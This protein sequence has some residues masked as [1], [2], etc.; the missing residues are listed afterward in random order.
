MVIVY[1]D[2][3]ANYKRL[4]YPTSEALY[5]VKPTDIVRVEGDG[6]SSTI[7]L[8]DKR[9]ILITK[10]LKW[11]RETLFHPFF[12]LCHQS[13]IINLNYMVKY[14]KL[15]ADLIHMVDEFRVPLS[16]GRKKEFLK[17]VNRG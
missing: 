1:Y 4:T 16:R 3:E 15:Q 8:T 2:D 5:F 12:F 10:G 6:N 11:T 7:F 9:K 14:Q 17:L 13:H